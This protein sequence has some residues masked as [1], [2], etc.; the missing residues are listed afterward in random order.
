[1]ANIGGGRYRWPGTPERPGVGGERRAGVSPGDVESLS[2]PVAVAGHAGS[3][4]GPALAALLLTDVAGL[5]DTALSSPPPSHLRDPL[6]PSLPPL[7]RLVPSRRTFCED[8]QAVCCPAQY[9]S[10]ELHGHL[11][12]GRG[13]ELEIGLGLK[14]HS[15]VAAGS[16]GGEHGPRGLRLPCSLGGLFSPPT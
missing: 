5:Q 14:L 1:M 8:G 13:P 12:C 7:S 3:R 10:R 2:T 4:G 6:Y 11:Q 16:Y 15:Q 9:S